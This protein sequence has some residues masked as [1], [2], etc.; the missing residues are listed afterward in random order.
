[1]SFTLSAFDDIFCTSWWY[2][3][4]FAK[5]INFVSIKMPRQLKDEMRHEIEC[6][7]AMG[8]KHTCSKTLGNHI[9]L[10][11]IS[12]NSINPCKYKFSIYVILI[13]PIPAYFNAYGLIL[14][15]HI[16]YAL[17]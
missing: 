3:N 14:D 15:S 1:M 16:L 5:Y 13:K 6:T 10:L 9:Y 17:H 2:I 7:A 8:N 12:Q 11:P 4:A